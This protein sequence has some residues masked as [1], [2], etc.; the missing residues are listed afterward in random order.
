VSAITTHLRSW[1]MSLARGWDAFWLTGQL[2]HTLAV[3]RILG[4]A[5]LFYTHLIWALNSSDFLGPHAWITRDVS[6]AM[7]AESFAFSIFWYFDSPIL[8]WIV[9]LITLVAMALLTLGLFTRPAAVVS[10]LAC[11]WYCHRLEGALFGLDQ[12]NA[13][14]A[15][16]LMIGRS[17]A[18]Y[19]IDRWRALRKAQR[20]DKPLPPLCLC[21]GTNLA[22]RLIQIHLCVIYLFG[23]LAKARGVMWWDGSAMWY[24]LASLEYQSW[25]LTW[26]IRHKGLL[27]TLTHV[28]LFWEISYAAL[29][30]PKATRPIVLALAFAAHAGIALFLGMITFGLAMLFANL[31]FVPATMTQTLVEA[32]NARLRNRRQLKAPAPR[33]P[34][35]SLPAKL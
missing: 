16:S 25:D 23:G 11:V 7:H 1:L 22:V 9:H 4:G 15:F 19:S 30:W 28:T 3:I 21:V 24:A 34:S 29:V 32:V 20:E 35:Q 13:M 26:M 14:L 27:S 31:A 18:V 10:W 8:L 12:V 17:G 2:P 5:M 6:L 33:S